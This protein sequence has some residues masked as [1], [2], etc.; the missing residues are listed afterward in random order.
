MDQR[1]LSCSYGLLLAVRPPA[2]YIIPSS[3]SVNVFVLVES[4][5]AQIVVPRSNVTLRLM[6]GVH[7]L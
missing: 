5:Y 1:V 6:I 4:M 3:F 2:L 7:S